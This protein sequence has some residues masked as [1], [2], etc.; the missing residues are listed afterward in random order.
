VVVACLFLLHLS[1]CHASP[2]RS[3]RTSAV[4]LHDI[5]TNIQGVAR[6]DLPILIQDYLIP[7][8]EN[9]GDFADTTNEPFVDQTI[10]DFG[11]EEPEMVTVTVFHS[12]LLGV[13]G[14]TEQTALPTDGD[15]IHSDLLNSGFFE[16]ATLSN[17]QGIM[18]AEPT[19]KSEPCCYLKFVAEENALAHHLVPHVLPTETTEL[20]HSSTV[21]EQPAAPTDPEELPLTYPLVRVPTAPSA[22][23][24]TVADF[25]LATILP[26]VKQ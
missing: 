10:Q 16:T 18:T 20:Y 15:E 7:I 3:P 9:N 12:Y 11:V 14:G 17:V 26:S 2:V 6:Y 19:Q 4:K 22:T 5:L 13:S 8:E 21:P 25:S 24:A 23:P 1:S